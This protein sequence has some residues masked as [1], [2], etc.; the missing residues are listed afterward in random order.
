[1]MENYPIDT[2]VVVLNHHLNAGI[3]VDEGEK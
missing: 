2:F 1:V 3:A